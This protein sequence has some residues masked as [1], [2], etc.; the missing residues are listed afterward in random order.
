MS[1]DVAQ[2][3]TAIGSPGD[4]KV[5]AD[6]RAEFDRTVLEEAERRSAMDAKAAADPENETGAKAAIKPSLPNMDQTGPVGAND[7]TDKP[8]EAATKTAAKKQTANRTR[9]ARRKRWGV[10][11]ILLL[12]AVVATS[13]AW[14]VLKPKELEEGFVSGNGRIEATEVEVAPKLAGRVAAILV[15]E[16]DFVERGQVVARMDNKVLDA[17][18]AEA[19]AEFA[20]AQSAIIIAQS[21]VSQQLSSRAVATA[22]VVQ[23]QAELTVAV[24]RL[25]RSRTLS[26]EGA[27]SIQDYDDDLA[28]QQK[29]VAAIEAAVA[30]VAAADAVI[31]TAHAQVSGAQ[32]GA[33]AA[34]AAIQRIDADIYDNSLKSPRDARVQ[35]RVAQP[36][37]VVA[38][39]GIVLDLVDLTDV[40]MTLFLP[41]ASVGQIALGAEVRIILDA[42]PQFVIPAKVSFIADVAQFTPKTVETASERQKL[43][44]RVKAQIDPTLLHRMIR[45]V[46]TGLPGMAYL[47]LD[48][49]RAWPARLAVHV[50]N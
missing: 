14:S 28:S 7:A 27:A 5:E 48:A 23:R 44:F 3:E 11:V 21:Q 19:V 9:G 2:T 33:V 8:G 25:E 39:G 29:S 6:R 4:R 34:G 15:N 43:M 45:Q 42:A 50:P 12:V 47:R 31:V 35:Y 49:Q 30:Q 16:G 38:A 24:K 32:A 17:Q 37:E 18:R 10:G 26:K 20:S 40:Y 41:D 46:K 22:V 1:D 36:D 13:V